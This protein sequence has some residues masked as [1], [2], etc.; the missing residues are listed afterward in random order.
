MKLGRNNHGNGSSGTL[1]AQIEETERQLEERRHDVQVHADTFIRDLQR[2]MS[3]PTTLLLAS[4]FGFIVGELTK[5]TS[6]K[7][8]RNDGGGIVHADEVSPLKEALDIGSFLAAVYQAVPLAWII[9]TFHPQ[10]APEAGAS[11]AVKNPA[12]KVDLAK[13]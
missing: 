11:D 10:E 4:E 6:K 9:D 13:K 12:A 5:R 2:E 1:A 3:S 8:R 7:E